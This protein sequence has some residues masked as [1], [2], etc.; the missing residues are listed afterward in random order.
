MQ[1]SW[2]DNRVSVVWTT[3]YFAVVHLSGVLFWLMVR[4]FHECGPQVPSHRLMLSSEDGEIGHLDGFCPCPY[5]QSCR[6]EEGAP[7]LGA[8][9]RRVAHACHGPSTCSS[10]THFRSPYQLEP[11]SALSLAFD[12]FEYLSTWCSDGENA[13][14]G[15]MDD[16]K[17]RA[18][19]RPRGPGSFFERVG[20]LRL[21]LEVN[22]I[23]PT[24]RWWS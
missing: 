20:S 11:Q 13:S 19:L 9:A 12:A 21:G 10:A 7:A 18:E 4:N 3:L 17:A 23:S 15:I 14:S 6:E 16:E 8:F 2:G 5:L 22:L 1:Q 24:T